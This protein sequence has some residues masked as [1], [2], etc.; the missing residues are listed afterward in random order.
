MTTHISD[1]DDRFGMFQYCVE[2]L[3][4]VLCITYYTTIIQSVDVF[5]NS[6]VVFLQYYLVP[7]DRIELPCPL[8]KSGILPLN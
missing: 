3:K 6:S 7:R 8:C 4:N 2:F 1:R 5:V